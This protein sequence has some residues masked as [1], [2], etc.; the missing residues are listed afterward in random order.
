M[1]ERHGY[2]QSLTLA[3][4]TIARATAWRTAPAFWCRESEP[5]CR[6]RP[7]ARSR[8]SCLPGGDGSGPRTP[9]MSLGRDCRFPR[10]GQAT[11]DVSA[12]TGVNR[13]SRS[14]SGRRRLGVGLGKLATFYAAPLFRRPGSSRAVALS[15]FLDGRCGRPCGTRPVC[16]RADGAPAGRVHGVQRPQRGPRGRRA[17]RGRLDGDAVR[18]AAVGC[19]C[20][21]GRQAEGRRPAADD[22][23]AAVPL[24]ARPARPQR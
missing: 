3:V 21:R 7:V 13:G 15:S 18:A 10:P 6:R 24:R 9:R 17:D 22:A 16:G 5:I 14:A 12:E 19:E 1:P 2:S 8:S 11:S 4:G 23:S 20:R